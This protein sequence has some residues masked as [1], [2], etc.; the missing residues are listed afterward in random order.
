MD[1]FRRLSY[2]K[3][4]FLR[5]CTLEKLCLKIIYTVVY[6]FK[7][8]FT[9]LYFRFIMEKIR[10]IEKKLLFILFFQFIFMYFF[11]KS[12]AFRLY[13]T[14]GNSTENKG[15]ASMFFIFLKERLKLRLCCGNLVCALTKILLFRNTRRVE[16]KTFYC[17]FTI[18]HVLHFQKG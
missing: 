9:P 6:N 4:H 5:L 10:E 14:P 16:F 7:L 3:A 13:C 15:S 12:P 17:I 18:L 8:S 1:I 11:S 2:H